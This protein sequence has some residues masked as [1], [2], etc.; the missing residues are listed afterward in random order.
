MLIAGWPRRVTLPN[1]KWGVLYGV[2][3]CNA[4]A[5]GEFGAV[6]V[7]SGR[8]TRPDRHHA[9]AGGEAVPGVQHAGLVRRRLLADALGPGDARRQGRHRAPR[10]PRPRPG[11]ARRGKGPHP[12][13]ITGQ[14]VT[15]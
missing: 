6:Y 2:I 10:L 12:M 9:A 7:V 3:L 14:N 1:I 11:R 5:M 13:S 4:R 15:R 8:I